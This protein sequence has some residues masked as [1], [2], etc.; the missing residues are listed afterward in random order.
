MQANVSGFEPWSWRPTHHR[1]I[2]PVM[3]SDTL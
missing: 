2:S 1:E 3:V